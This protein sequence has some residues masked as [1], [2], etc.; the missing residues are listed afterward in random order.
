MKKNTEIR[1]TGL[2][3]PGF[4]TIAFIILKLCHVINWS[5]VWVVSPVW[6]GLALAIILGIVCGIL[7]ARDE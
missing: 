6:I 3:F 7:K 5:W 4:L 1:K 2:G